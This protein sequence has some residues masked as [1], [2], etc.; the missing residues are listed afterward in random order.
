MFTSL[1]SDIQ[2]QSQEQDLKDRLWHKGSTPNKI[3]V[4]EKYL[5]EYNNRG[6]AE[7]LLS[8]FKYD[9]R[10]QNTGP[11]IYVWSKSIVSVETHKLN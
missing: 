9:F 5:T 10:L 8:G 4:L 11:R 2:R 1:L 6:D 7:L 3:N